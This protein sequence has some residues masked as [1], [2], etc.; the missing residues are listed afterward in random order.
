[1]HSVVIRRHNKTSTNHDGDT[2]SK[3]AN[4]TAHSLHIKAIDGRVLVNLG[5]D[6]IAKPTTSNVYKTLLLAS[7]DPLHQVIEVL[8]AVKRMNG[9]G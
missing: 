7:F 9:T 1:M 2:D 4:K 8:C 5:E 6:N 3:R